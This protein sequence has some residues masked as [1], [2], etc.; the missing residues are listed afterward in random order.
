MLIAAKRGYPK[1][2]I[3]TTDIRAVVILI[4]ENGPLSEYIFAGRIPN[5]SSTHKS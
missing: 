4:S 2:I 5:K 3:E 1:R